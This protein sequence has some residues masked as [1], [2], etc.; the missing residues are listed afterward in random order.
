MNWECL[1]HPNKPGT[2]HVLPTNDLL[3]HEW[4][5]CACLPSLSPVSRPDGS[6]GWLI[7]HSAWDGRE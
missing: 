4:V 3:A 2:V 5:D 6:Y 7:T 1:E